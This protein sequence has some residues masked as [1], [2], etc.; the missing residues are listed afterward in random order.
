MPTQ[1]KWIRATT[2]PVIS[3]LSEQEKIDRH[4]RHH[5]PRRLH[6]RRLK[7]GTKAEKAYGKKHISE[8]HRHRY[9]FN[10]RYADKLEKTGLVF[11]GILEEGNLCEIAE[12]TDHPW[13]LGVQ[14]HPEFKSK[15]TDPHPLFR[16]FIEALMQNQQETKTAK[17]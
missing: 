14:F 6:L 16:S 12:V 7:P 5:A 13:M 15:P 10:N 8:R 1:Q 2:N 11:S 4:G 3:L 9:E 17:R